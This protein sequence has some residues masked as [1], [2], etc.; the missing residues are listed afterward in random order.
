MPGEETLLGA[1][2]AGAPAGDGKGADPNANPAGAGAGG[3]DKGKPADPNGG[4]QG[5]PS[6][7]AGDGKQPD[8]NDPDKN[9]APQGAPDKYEEFKLPQGMALV[10]EIAD[11]FKTVAKELNL[12]QAAAQKLVDIQAKMA[13][14]AQEAGLKEFDAMKESWR[15]ETLKELG[16]DA[17]AQLGIAAKAIDRFGSP[18]LRQMLNDTGL[19]NHKDLVS[20]LVKVGK[21]ISE[22]KLA[23]GK[24]AGGAK[25]AADV[26]YPSAQK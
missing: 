13:T 23:D 19:G 8:P 21:A 14:H 9:K 16:S 20:F 24:P 5:D 4:G 2:A 26:L 7:K 11:E 22:D 12:S 15:T 10:P 3:P 17:Q 1:P 18:A 25:S 6:K